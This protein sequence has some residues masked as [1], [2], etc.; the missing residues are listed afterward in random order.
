MGFYV[1]LSSQDGKQLYSGNS[2]S[3]FIVQLP[4]QLNLPAEWE[5]SLRD[6]YIQS[7]DAQRLLVCY[8][9]V[10]YTIV[11]NLLRPLLRGV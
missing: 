5:V 3:E 9:V 6:I 7:Q 10:D 2:G 1:L 4:H 8:D 11:S